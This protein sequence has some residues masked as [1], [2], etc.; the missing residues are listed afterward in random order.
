MESIG[1]RIARLRK[2]KDWSRPELGRQ[3]AQAIERAKPFSG[4]AV[5]RYEQGPD[6][7]GKAARL[8]LAK[9][10]GKTEAYI[11][12]GDTSQPHKAAQST[13]QYNVEPTDSKEE[14]ALYLFHN[15]IEQQQREVIKHLRAFF[16]AN[17]A[18]RK[19]MGGKPLRGVSDA[20]V[21]RAFGEAPHVRRPRKAMKKKADSGK[22]HRQ[23]GDAMGDYLD[24]ND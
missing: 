6:T 7:P 14:L 18:I 23:P 1:E 13:S 11:V 21:E 8:A 24:E 10:F 19:Q 16:E 3:M 4:E 9:V 22:R 20:D 5:R 15:L 12:F 2:S 17:Q